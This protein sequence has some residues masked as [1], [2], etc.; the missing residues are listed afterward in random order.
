MYA[1]VERKMTCRQLATGSK[2]KAEPL[3]DTKYVIESSS[4]QEPR[5]QML[6]RQLLFDV[7]H[8]VDLLLMGVAVFTHTSHQT[9]A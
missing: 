2:V 3:N 9:F 1:E 6:T 7:L 8:T 4:L 5:E